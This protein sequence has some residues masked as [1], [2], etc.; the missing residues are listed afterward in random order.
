MSE[1]SGHGIQQNHE[2]TGIQAAISQTPIGQEASVGGASSEI[3]SPAVVTTE[4]GHVTEVEQQS[5]LPLSPL[6]QNHRI[7]TRP[8]R[9]FTVNHW[10]E[11]GRRP[12]SEPYWTKELAEYYSQQ[13]SELAGLPQD[14]EGLNLERVSAYM[15]SLGVRQPLTIHVSPDL[16]PV[17]VPYV[18]EHH[19]LKREEGVGGRYIENLDICIVYRDGE[20]EAL[21]GPEYVES[22][23]VHELYHGSAEH[24][25][26]RVTAAAN[27]GGYAH[28]IGFRSGHYVTRLGPRPELPIRQTR[29][30]GFLE[31]GAAEHFR[32][33]YIT[34]VLG[35]PG[36][37]ADMPHE[38]TRLG[39]PERP[40]LIPSRY[41]V[42]IREDCPTVS[43]AS[44]AGAAMD[45]LVEKDPALE[46]AL[47][48]ARYSVEGLREVAGR[49]EAIRK[50]LY[51]HL[52]DN[53]TDYK[54]YPQALR[55]V[56]KVLGVPDHKS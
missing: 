44:F 20:L 12:Q 55:N 32:G 45:L 16:R 43:Q 4:T 30:G 36:G 56:R 41:I 23:T 18:S 13:Q 6:P 17:V 29:T 48:E 1:L 37:L 52:R 42:K 24:A 49:I 5:D 53:Y 11:V 31:E 27:E 19:S 3:T 38:L 35:K 34:E 10:G 2:Q 22:L 46:P 8:L 9:F 25:G 51:P 7:T 15:G 47:L 21:N 54:R 50:G 40:L 26:I 39:K 33:K 14:T 28:R